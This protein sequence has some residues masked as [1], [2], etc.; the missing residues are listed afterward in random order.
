MKATKKQIAK[1]WTLAQRFIMDPEALHDFVFSITGEKHIS[2]LNTLQAGHVLREMEHYFGKNFKITGAQR[3]KVLKLMYL[4]DWTIPR[5]N[6]MAKRMF[7][8]SSYL[9]LTREQ[10]WKL[11]E[12]LKKMEERNRK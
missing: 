4:M 1:I 6:G 8:V 12:A 7:K 3:S 9:W 10:G 11:I 5:I 2:K